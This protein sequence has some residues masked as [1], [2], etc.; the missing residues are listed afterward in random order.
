LNQIKF[1]SDPLPV[2]RFRETSL[3]ICGELGTNEEDLR[4]ADAGPSRQL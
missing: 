3:P 2:V 4:K 1:Q